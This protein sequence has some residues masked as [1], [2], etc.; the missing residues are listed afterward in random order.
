MGVGAADADTTVKVTPA[1]VGTSWSPNDTRAGGDVDFVNGPATPPLG[2][3]SLRM[4][5]TD[6][7]GSSQAK[8]QLFTYDHVGVA[9]ADID[10]MTY[11]VYRDSAST[12]SPAQ[13]IS[14]N[15]EVDFVGDGLSFTT[16]VFE[17]TYNGAQG[18]M[19]T[20]TWQDWD[21]H[22]GGDA[23]WWSTKDI[24]GACAF[25]CF[26]SWD[27]IVAN[28]PDAVVSGGFGLNIGSGW[29]GEFS[30]NTDALSLG[31]D[32][33]TTTYDFEP[34][35]NTPQSKNDCKKGGWKQYEDDQYRP[36][37][38]QGDCV[39]YVATGGRNKAG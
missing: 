14:L 28:N 22:A 27:T 26:V 18:P 6:D 5:T 7:L 39:S 11:A 38:N 31:I 10:A 13:T 15:V 34:A 33:S 23:R 20:D 29:A 1:D 32:G 30:G 8:A 3:G 25:N 21:A 12:N 17:P 2:I 16:L 19:L 36:F 9:L 24:P 4:T 35:A 37:K